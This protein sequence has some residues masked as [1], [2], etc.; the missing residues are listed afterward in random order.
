MILFTISI[1]LALAV[2]SVFALIAKVPHQQEIKDTLLKL[3]FHF[4][5]MI[6]SIKKLVLLLLRDLIETDLSILV[7]SLTNKT[8]S[9][10]KTFTVSSGLENEK[11]HKID[12]KKE[13][14]NQ[15]IDL[16]DKELDENKEAA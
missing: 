4:A 15:I 8:F 14:K 3:G 10:K 13:Q 1:I 11:T 9:Q 2:W 12:S 5:E 16:S 6:K 7:N